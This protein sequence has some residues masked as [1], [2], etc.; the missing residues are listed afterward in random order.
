MALLKKAIERYRDQNQGPII[1]ATAKI[2][3]K[4]TLGSFVRLRIDTDARGRTIVLGVRANGEEVP[5]TGM[6]DG[7]RDQLYLALRLAAIEH[8]LTQNEPL[9]LIC[10]DLLVNFDDERSLA[11]LKILADLAGK[12][13]VIFFTHHSKIIEQAQ[14]HLPKQVVVH[15][16]GTAGLLDTREQQSV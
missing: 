2:F 10:D 16:L 8:H 12:T 3:A 4:L 9:P 6:S 1:N 13:Q 14:K 7:T 15:R 11:A 5:V